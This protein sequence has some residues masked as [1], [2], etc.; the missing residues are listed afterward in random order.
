M[1]TLKTYI[2]EALISSKNYTQIFTDCSIKE[3]FKP[4]NI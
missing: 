1:K 2:H 3:K 4:K